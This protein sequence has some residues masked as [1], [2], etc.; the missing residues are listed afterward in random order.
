MG[1]GKGKFFGE[2]IDIIMFDKRMKILREGGLF[3]CKEYEVIFQLT[4]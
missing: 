2:I 1:M 3:A 4:K